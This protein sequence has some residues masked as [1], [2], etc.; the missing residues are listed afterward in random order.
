MGES[1]PP[2]SPTPPGSENICQQLDG[3]ISLN[4]S[5]SSDVNN[6]LM[7]QKIIT[8]MSLPKVATYNL[9]SMIPKIKSLK[10]D[11]L[12]REIDCAFLTEIWQQMANKEHQYEIEKMLEMSGLA[13][14]S[15]PRPPNAK[16]VSYG[17]AAIV[18][19]TLKFSLEKMKVSIPHNLE[20]VWGMIKPREV[21]A[22]FKQIIVCAFYSPPS[23][24][25]NSKM[26]DHIASTLHMLC[27]QYP[28][29]GIIL[30]ADRNNMNI[31]PILNCGLKLRQ[32]VDKCTRQGQILDILIMNTWAYYNTPI[33][34]PPINP[35]NPMK[36]KASDHWV[37]VCTPHTDRYH[38]PARNY[39]IIKYRPLP[40]S[41]LRKLGEWIVNEDW[42][43]VSH[44][45]SVNEQVTSFEELVLDKL[46]TFCPMK[47]MKISSHDKLFI[48]A[49][50][51]KLHRLRSREYNRRGK[52]KKYKELANLFKIKYKIE[53]KKFL[54]KNVTE[55]KTGNPG[56]A[57]NVLK[58]LGAQPGDCDILNSFT[59]PSHLD[60]NLTAQESAERIAD[61]FSAI[62]K[63]F[64]P[65]DV[66]LLPPHVQTK[67]L[68]EGSPPDISE[69]ETYE[70]IRTAKKPKSGVPNDLPKQIVQEFS[71]ELAEPIRRIIS[72]IAKTGQWPKQWKLEHV[73]PLSKVLQP[74]S[75][76]DLRPISLTPFFSKVTE[77][78]VVQWIMEYIED[79]IDCRQYGG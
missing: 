18:V 21:S 11:I 70:K 8:A 73:T 46:N 5:I 64:T 43:S 72:N 10:T 52:T 76:D 19:N 60:E 47:E 55:L 15:C 33:I 22:K 34:A 14:I 1:E 77:Q 35:D 49:E 75:E 23:K 40:E 65:L 79:K 26:A 74:E 41:G 7:P 51:K 62:S 9:R 38:P 69:Y 32:V 36:G 28:E 30:G 25:S 20:I 56:K 31:K 27:T 24:R 29:C 39:R 12:E 58:R 66:E 78:F 61:H 54:D 57:Y 17:G 45:Q 50:L 16:G 59:L 2:A 3:N 53:A 4:S 42:E 68:E 63:E 13:Y 67:L 6:F 71:P 44:N 37:P 48:N